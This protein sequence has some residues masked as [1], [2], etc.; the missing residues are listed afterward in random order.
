MG[1]QLAKSIKIKIDHKKPPLLES[2]PS[3]AAVPF[4]Y[5]GVSYYA[6]ICIC[7]VEE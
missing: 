5:K 3:E 7:G 4:L 6:C 1:I 2:K